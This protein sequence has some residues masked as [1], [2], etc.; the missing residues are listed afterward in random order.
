MIAKNPFAEKLEIICSQPDARGQFKILARING[1]DCHHDVFDPYKNYHR[2]L[3]SQAVLQ[4]GGDEL[5]GQSR[6]LSSEE[7]AE[8][9]PGGS[10]DDSQA[11]LESKLVAIGDLVIQAVKG[12]ESGAA[13]RPMPL[14]IEALAAKHPDLAEPVIYGIAR[15]G[16]TINL[17]AAPKTGKSWTVYGLLLSIIMGWDWLD[18][19]RC[20]R[21]R[22]LLIDNELHPATLVHRIPAVADAMGIRHEDYV[23]SLDILSLR[24]RLMDLYAI[25]QALE[26]IPPDTYSLIAFDAFY[27]GYPPGISENDNAGVAML[28]NRIDQVAARLNCAWLNVH[29]STKGS[30]ADKAITDVG[31]GAG[32]QSRAADAHIILRPHEATNAIV[33]DGVVRSFAPI[34][35]LALKWEFPVW[36]PADELDPAA[37][38]G[39]A[40]KHEDRQSEKDRAVL[41]KIREAL[42]VGPQTPRALRVPT[43]ATRERLQRLLDRLENRKEVAWTMI[44]IKGRECRE[45]RLVGAENLVGDFSGRVGDFESPTSAE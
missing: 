43:E 28:Y 36:R 44:E 5:N 35:P 24:G 37:V 34:Q 32:S 15:K 41:D 38:K 29:H 42:K 26:Q 4:K 1:E 3:F 31:A 33:L 23:D 19:Y 30:Q 8:W 40:G 25:A 13:N 12:Y 45:Y 16:E 14:G 10:E 2:G 9:R 6:V 7:L 20:S 17:I 27:R 18:R 39:R 11:K 21:G 22:V